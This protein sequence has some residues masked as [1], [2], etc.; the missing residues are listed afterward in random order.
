MQSV[1]STTVAHIE[2][3]PSGIC[4]YTPL[5]DH[6]YYIKHLKG[7]GG[8]ILGCIIWGG[9]GARSALLLLLYLIIKKKIYNN[10][11]KNLLN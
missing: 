3:P 4:R 9:G 2:Q 7:Q 6:T 1:I 10:F 8:N 5:W 11:N